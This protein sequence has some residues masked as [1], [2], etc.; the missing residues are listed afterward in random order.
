MHYITQIGCIDGYSRGYLE[1]EYLRGR[2]VN[3]F[4][5]MFFLHSDPEYVIVAM[6][7][8]LTYVV[9]GAYPK[10][11]RK[12]GLFHRMP[13]YEYESGTVPMKRLLTMSA[14]T[15]FVFTK[16]GRYNLS[17]VFDGIDAFPF[18][19]LHLLHFG[20]LRATHTKDLRFPFSAETVCAL[21][22]PRDEGVYEVFEGRRGN[23]N[24]FNRNR[25]YVGR[26]CITNR[27]LAGREYVPTVVEDKLG[28]NP[29]LYYVREGHLLSLTPAEYA[30]SGEPI[31]LPP[32]FLRFYSR[33][34]EMNSPLGNLFAKQGV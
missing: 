9:A 20:E 19:N 15:I 23:E 24:D 14:S 13:Y 34:G 3:D 8:P 25:N 18:A 32:Y 12:V 2:T 1:K 10:G 33:C 17:P 21:L 29:L 22:L 28:D 6:A 30:D 5:K 31:V 27:P 16:D 11:D 26:L 4:A 7:D